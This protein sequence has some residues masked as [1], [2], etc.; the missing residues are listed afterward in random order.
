MVSQHFK[1]Y[2]KKLKGLEKQLKSEA[3]CIASVVKTN[4]ISMLIIKD[5]LKC[6]DNYA[7]YVI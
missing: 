7:A 5:Q 6:L 2:G 1:Q 4:F 3:S